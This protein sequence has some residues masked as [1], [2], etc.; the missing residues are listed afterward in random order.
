ML[1]IIKPQLLRTV[2]EKNK[3]TKN[4]NK[5]NIKKLHNNYKE[6]LKYN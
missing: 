3:M 4:K 2:F 6:K 5:L 1:R